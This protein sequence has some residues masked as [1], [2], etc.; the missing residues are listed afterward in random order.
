MPKLWQDSIAAHR[1]AV[2]EAV[3]DTVGA[4][5]AEQG[6]HAVTM[7]RLAEDTGIGRATL[8]KYFPDLAAAL[9]AW[10]QR[11]VHRHLALLTQVGNS[12]GSAVRRLEAVLAAY[13]EVSR[14]QHGGELASL[15]HQGPHVAQAQQH[16]RRL[17]ADLVAQGA[18]AGEL[19]SDVAPTELAAFCLHALTAASAVPSRAAVG[20]LVQVTLTG[21]RPSGAARRPFRH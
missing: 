3:L 9:D 10:H 6:L 5:V 21:L 4:L 19:R 2:R 13:A 1:G 18:A 16:L 20:R 8:Y 17:I 15:L 14:Q 11:Q 12:P 7:S